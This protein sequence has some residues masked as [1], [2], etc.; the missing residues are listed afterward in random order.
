MSV[1]MGKTAVR[2]LIIVILVAA[3]IAPAVGEDEDCPPIPEALIVDPG[4]PVEPTDE[5]HHLGAGME[6]MEFQAKGQI[7]GG[8]DILVEG[9]SEEGTLCD[10]PFVVSTVEG[11]CRKYTERLR[12]TS[13]DFVH[14]YEHLRNFPPD[15]VAA[16]GAQCPIPAGTRL[17]QVKVWPVQADYSHVHYE[18]L[19]ASSGKLRNPV[20]WIEPMNDEVGPEIWRPEFFDDDA[21]VCT[22]DPLVKSFEPMSEGCEAIKGDV[23]IVVRVA[24]YHRAGRPAQIADALG[25]RAIRYRICGEEEPDCDDWV[26]AFDL[27][28]MPTE[29]RS[30]NDAT[31]C[32]ITSTRDPAQSQ[33]KVWKQNR[34]FLVPTN[35]AAADEPDPA[36]AWKTDEDGFYSITIEAT[37]F[38]GNTTSRTD[39]VCVDNHGQSAG[40]LVIRDCGFHSRLQ[41][42]TPVL[43]EERPGVL[44][45]DHGGEPSPCK[46]V[47]SPDIRGIDRDNGKSYLTVC[48][49]NLGRKPIPVAGSITAVFALHELSPGFVFGLPDPPLQ[50]WAVSRPISEFVD[51]DGA[52]LSGDWSVGQQRCTPLPVKDSVLESVSHPIN[53]TGSL[54]T[55]GDKPNSDTRV[56]YDNNKSSAV[57]SLR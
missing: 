35:F 11:T 6:F 41:V 16:C 27:D 52:P 15:I 9:C 39:P 1:G 31:S 40:K 20:T 23:D 47:D 19:Q 42:D 48:A 36:G 49:W 10:A 51:I 54:S 37:D 25:P 53:V 46:W 7:H 22:E 21:Q 14:T 3:V 13:G 12:V 44:E 32:T 5:Q 29:W 45:E 38:A 8:L 24:D 43:D 4:W 18:V 30:E 17:A 57:I 50:E 2:R 56:R 26:E 28:A 33:S 55:D 34:F